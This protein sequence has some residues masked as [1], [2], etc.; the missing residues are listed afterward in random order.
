MDGY[1]AQDSSVT[2]G[3]RSHLMEKLFENMRTA[4]LAM[5]IKSLASG[6]MS[7]KVSLQEE[8]ENNAKDFER[9]WGI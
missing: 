9:Q 7:T 4:L 3:P 6:W 5:P 2:Q 8:D 1:V